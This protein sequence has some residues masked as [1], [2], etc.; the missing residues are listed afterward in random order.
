MKAKSLL[1]GLFCFSFISLNAQTTEYSLF[2]Q[3]S[4]S[5][6][7]NTF[8]V[9]IQMSFN[10]NNKLGSSNLVFSYDPTV[11]NEPVLDS[12][13]LSP[14]PFYQVPTLTR[15][16]SNT[17]SFNIDLAVAGFGDNI[18]GLPGRTQ[19]ASVCFDVVDQTQLIQLDWIISGSSGT[20]IYLDD[21]ATQLS[22]GIVE[23]YTGSVFPVEW[24]SFTAEGVDKHV[25]LNWET[26]REINN[27]HFDIERSIDGTLF[28][29]IGTKAGQ[30]NSEVVNAYKFTDENALLNPTNKLF[31]RLK[32]VD[33]DG[34]FSYSSVVE[35]NVE[36]S[37]FDFLK[38]FPSPFD[39]KLTLEYATS[40]FE[41]AHMDISNTLG[42]IV[43]EGQP[44][45]NRG[46][47]QVE[48]S[49]WKK[50]VYF[51]RLKGINSSTVYKILKF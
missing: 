22:Q 36:I 9:D 44:T 41:A 39:D 37:E 46:S 49:A 15:P 14:P 30:G 27:D 25:E 35:I 29:K 50:G 10:Q 11:I 45:Q 13:N 32:Q 3:K 6:N 26:E 33:L 24:L 51:A 8:C 4:S 31:Y 34:T 28:E 16:I 1:F 2:L 12:E 47:M 18:S 40:D 42:Q 5:P 20:V 7:S 38:T 17:A 19:I 23:G 48:T 43:W 21:E